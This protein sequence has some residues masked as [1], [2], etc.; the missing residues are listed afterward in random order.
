MDS[1][2]TDLV[3]TRA[4]DA[5]LGDRLPGPG[6][7]AVERVTTGHSNELFRISRG[8]DNWMLRR[9]PRVSNTPGAH[10]MAREYRVLTALEGTSVPH[11]TPRGLCDDESVIGA[12][13]YVVDQIIGTPL[14]DEIPKSL[15]GERIAI[16]NEMIDALAALHR[17]DWQAAGL[18]GFGRPDGYAERQAARWGK[19]LA[20]YAFRDLPELDEVAAWIDAECPGTSGATLIHGDYG[21]HNVMF[22]PSAPAELLAIIDW[23]TSTIGDP[24]ADL[25]YLLAFWLQ[26]EDYPQWAELGPAYP[27]DGFPDRDAL[28]ARYAA[29][30]GTELTADDLRWYRVLGHFKIA[31]ILEGSYGRYV[32]GEADDEYF[33]SLDERVPLLARHALAIAANDA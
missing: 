28:I 9:P 7:L 20:S 29:A 26:P 30:V 18:D 25:G 4:L 6:P 14:Y 31:V 21:L 16:A 24:L 12:P 2:E 3:P 1:R 33:A 23:E 13:F 15:A 19:Q 5:W 17:V 32:R 27:L 10:D 22:A 11:A 8:E